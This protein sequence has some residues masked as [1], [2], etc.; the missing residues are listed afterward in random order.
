METLVKEKKKSNL[1]DLTLLYKSNKENPVY[2]HSAIGICIGASTISLVKLKYLTNDTIK[3][4]NKESIT[5]NG[6]PLQKTLDLIDKNTSQNTS[7][8][9]TGR[10]SRN[11]IDL[12][13]ISEV[14]AIE[15]ALELLGYK[16]D[17]IEGVTNLGAETFILYK[18][19]EK[20]K[21]QQQIS[22]N[23]CASGTGEFFKQQIKRMNVNLEQA[24]NVDINQE[25]YHVSGRCSVFC[26]SDCTHAL[27]KGIVKEKVIL[28]LA[29]MISDKIYQLIKKSRSKKFLVTGGV[30]QNKAVISL[31]R[32]KNVELVVPDEATFFEAIGAAYYGLTNDCLNYSIDKPIQITQQSQFS[33][34][35]PLNHYKDRVIF[36]CDSQ[37]IGIPNSECIIGI[38]VGSTTTKGVAINLND[39]KIIAKEY[40]Y[41]NGNPIESSRKVYK[42]LSDQ[43]QNKI[44]IVGIGITGSGRHI[45][46]LYSNTNSIYNEITAHAKAAVHFDPTVDTIFEIGGQDA[47]YM[48]INNQV[49]SDYAMNEACSAGTGSFIEEAAFESL[50]IELNQLETTALNSK[51]PI[52]FRDQCSA[53]I[54]SDIKRAI[55]EGFS[56]E[57]I[58]AG[59]VYS[60]CLNYA[61]RV[62][63]KRQIGKKIFMQGGVSYNKSIP[64]AMA[65]VTGKEIIVPPFPGLMGAYGAALKVFED[66][67]IGNTKRDSFSFE[68]LLDTKIALKKT[69]ICND[70]TNKCNRKCTI[71][72]FSIK[73]KLIPFGGAC[74]KYYN[75][76]D[77]IEN[78]WEEKDFVKDRMERIFAL[79]NVKSLLNTG[80]SIGF[81]K[82]FAQN[83]LFPL[84]YTFFRKL[85]FQVLLPD[86]KSKCNNDNLYSSFCYPVEL[87][88]NLFADL[89]SKQP[90]YFFIPQIYEMPVK[91]SEK[92]PKGTCATCVFVNKESN[93]LYQ[94]FKNKIKKESLIN[95][96]LN[97]IKGYNDQKK[98]FIDI[99]ERLGISNK[100]IINKAFDAAVSYQEKVEQ[101]LYTLGKS[102]I[103]NLESNPN[104]T[105]IV[106]IGRDYN[107]FSEMANM[108]IPK[109][110]ASLGYKVIPYDIIDN[111]GETIDSY[112]SWEAGKRILRAAKFIKR[113]NQLFPVYIT[114][115]SCGPDSMIIPQFRDI[116]GLKPNLTLELDK[117]TADAGINT[118]IDAFIDVVKNF[119]KLK[120]NPSLK[121]TDLFRPANISNQS[122]TLEF[123]DS[124]GNY[125]DLKDGEV[126]IVIPAMG[127]MASRLFAAS[128]KSLGYNAKSLPQITEEDLNVGLNFTTGKECLPIILS[129][130]SMMNY[131]KKYRR[132][133]K[134]TVVLMIG[135]SGA[136]RVGQ[137]P[138]VLKNIIKKEKIKNVAVLILTSEEGYVGFSNKFLI[139]SIKSVILNDVLEDVRSGILANAI[140]SDEG[141]KIFNNQLSLLEK[142][143]AE[144]F[145]NLKNALK[146]FSNNI[147][148]SIS[149]KYPISNFRQIALTGEIFVRHNQFAHNYLNHYFGKHGFVLK[150]SYISE[151]VKYIDYA[152]RKNVFN[153][154]ISFPKKI[155]RLLREQF[156]SQIEKKYKNILYKTGFISKDHISVYNIVKHSL[157]ALPLESTGEPA[158]T[159]GTALAYGYEKFAGIINIGPFGCLQTRVAEAICTPNMN[160][161]SKK[162]IKNELR[163]PYLIPENLTEKTEIP[164]L[165]IECDG[166][167]FPQIIES[168]LETFLL[169][170]KRSSE[171]M[172]INK[173]TE[174][175]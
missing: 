96:Y 163:I 23:Q 20:Y 18:I 29:D 9:I 63:G 54:G 147:K 38:D 101:E 113:H 129:A 58:S 143:I 126:E 135:G 15:S 133:E 148:K 7:V 145:K 57:D 120:N 162:E 81:N 119:R 73:D 97:F 156:I 22:D 138:V 90:D 144:D 2:N 175:M 108:G 16:Y 41:T 74:N 140:D 153:P 3:V 93:I 136:C 149:F 49:P 87:A 71:N 170:I 56:K 62:K 164:F 69:F 122:G 70:R 44:K 105:A 106:L 94:A 118:R 104:E 167:G 61:N 131:L 79:N 77:T 132:G 42:S 4:S 161:G 53:L 168:K 39:K 117:H 31:I 111:S 115:F 82:S 99:G 157:H 88:H 174:V 6:D 110:L 40:L 78:E 8:I 84:F 152:W 43:I 66:I 26:K 125:F 21:V 60:I 128:M 55:Q 109:K 155:G 139:R 112:Q 64:I 114:N 65:A 160:L 33:F 116:M 95:P 86:N 85:G 37:Y 52:N 141:L 171:N 166:Q 30:S 47:K 51:K 151:W 158:L 150:D 80:K 154:E 68:S 46:A 169:Q 137:Y 121:K 72:V 134:K 19:N 27:N 173:E 130:G 89:I 98:V 107:A 76:L 10:S 25:A 165:T 11:N 14:Q 28:G 59:L 1:T 142:N 103:E 17:G 91:G 123:V 34:H 5:N 83:R 13:N 146:L 48:F 36:K 24:S 35:K 159:L 172:F 45:S 124:C 102:L 127:Y 67:E 75:K 12:I 92:D 32:K 50:G 100:T